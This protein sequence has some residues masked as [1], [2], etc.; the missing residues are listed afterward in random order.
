MMNKGKRYEVAVIDFETDPFRFGRVPV[1]FACGVLWRGI[2]AEFWGPE[3]SDAAVAWLHTIDMPLV[4]YAHNGGRFD[5]F[6][7]WRAL[8]NPIMLIDSRIVSAKLGI[9]E[10][11]DSWAIMPFALGAYKK[12]AIDYAW[13]EPEQREQHRDAI[14]SYLHDDCTD[15]MA[16]CSAFIARFGLQL[17]AAGTAMR[18][19]VKL[20]PQAPMQQTHDLMFRP[21]YYG[22]RVECFESGILEGAF[23]L[24][25][26]NSMYPHVMRE[27]DHPLGAQYV[28]V[29]NAYLDPSGWIKGYPECLYFAEVEG[30][31][32]GALPMRIDGAHGGLSFGVSKGRFHTTSHE[33]RE[34]ILLGMFDADRVVC[35]WLPVHTQRFAAFVDAFSAEK[36]AAKASG[37]RISELFAKLVMNSAYGKFGQNPADFKEWFIQIRGVHAQPGPGWDLEQS[38]AHWCVWSKPAASHRYFD[39]AIAASVTSAARA[40][41]LRAIAGAVRPIYCDTDSLICV[42]LNR[43]AKVDS[44]AL[45]AWKLET[46]G[47]VA[48]VA[49][50]KLYALGKRRPGAT[51]EWVKWASKGTKLKPEEI[52]KIARGNSVNWKSEAP[53]FSLSG[54]V[55][56]V[57]RVSKM[58][59]R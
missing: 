26:V 17:T 4:V 12:T 49:G 50:K 48:A 11:R 16:L 21:F 58:T 15:L 52:E 34:A 28:E 46:E 22:G 29:R 42:A 25:D 8:G 44:S 5:F 10:L 19:L 33:L 38:A 45:G 18:E 13:F 1:P 56:F 24:Y 27:F 51:T 6:F 31:N 14:C 32:R 39:V 23:R 47:D 55:K 57:E 59:A 3:C 35:A 36:I 9:H 43:H 40:V 30:H 37:D 41:L 2:Y 20:H 53:T 7:L 54:N